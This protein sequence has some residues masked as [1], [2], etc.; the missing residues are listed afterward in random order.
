MTTNSSTTKRKQETF[1]KDLNYYLGLPYTVILERWDDGNGPYWVAR[2]AELPHCMTTG[3]SPQEAV[4]EVEEVKQEWIMSNLARGI[5]IPEPVLRTHSGQIS[6]RIPPTLHRTLA[7]RAYVEGISLNQY[8][9]AALG[10]TVG[11]D[12]AARR[13][14]GRKKQKKGQP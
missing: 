2:V 13:P 11:F 7:D 8:M 14:S 9:T 10:Q 5:K 4:A 1:R 6:L 3:D 12:I